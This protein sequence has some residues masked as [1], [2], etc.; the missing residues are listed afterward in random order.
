MQDLLSDGRR[1]Y[2]SVKEVAD[3]LG[4]SRSYLYRLIEEGEVEACSFGRAKR[5]ARAEILRLERDSKNG[6]VA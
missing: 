2:Y 3:Y 4:L 1:K 5:I 6:A